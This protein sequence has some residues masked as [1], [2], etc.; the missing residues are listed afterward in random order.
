[1][2]TVSAGPGQALAYRVTM[3]GGSPHDPGAAPAQFDPALVSW[4]R[5]GW[6]Q[7]GRGTGSQCHTTPPLGRHGAAALRSCDGQARGRPRHRGI[8]MPGDRS[9]TPAVRDTATRRDTQRR[10]GSHCRDGE[11]RLGLRSRTRAETWRNMGPAARSQLAWP[12]NPTGPSSFSVPT[13]C[14][15]V[16]PRPGLAESRVARVAGRPKRRVAP[17]REALYKIPSRYFSASHCV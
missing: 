5:R 13:G 15:T 1:M 10:R 16:Q 2:G 8:S 17:S 3:T 4:Q 11:V 14:L 12:R 6:G 7:R 9:S